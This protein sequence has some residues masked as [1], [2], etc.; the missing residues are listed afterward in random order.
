MWFSE[1]TLRCPEGRKVIFAPG[2]TAAAAVK[3][4]MRPPP[5]RCVKESVRLIK[6]GP[7][8]GLPGFGSAPAV[9][10]ADARTAISRS[11]RAAYKLVRAQSCTA[12]IEA[13]ADWWAAQA[14]AG[15]N[16]HH[17][18]RDG[19]VARVHSYQM[20]KVPWFQRHVVEVCRR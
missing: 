9:H 13:Y 16:L 14:V 15:E 4:G 3:K 6:R 1:I 19:L 10:A 12:A 20:A 18:G 11:N 5:G 2:P 17:A 8:A 7:S